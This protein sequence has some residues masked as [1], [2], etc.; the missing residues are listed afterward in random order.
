[1]KLPC[2]FIYANL[3]VVSCCHGVVAGLVSVVKVFSDNC[4]VYSRG[5]ECGGFFGYLSMCTL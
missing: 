4:S 2:L 5:I 1:M 3:K